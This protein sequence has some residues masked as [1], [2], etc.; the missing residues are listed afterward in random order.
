MTGTHSFGYTNKQIIQRLIFILAYV[1]FG[2]SFEEKTF[3]SRKFTLTS[4]AYYIIHEPFKSNENK[5]FASN[6]TEKPKEKEV[7]RINTH[8]RKTDSGKFPSN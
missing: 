6:R 1:Y 2:Y 3:S 8:Q 7:T 4:I 5:L